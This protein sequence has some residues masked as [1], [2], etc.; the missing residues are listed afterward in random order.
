MDYIYFWFAKPLG[1]FVGALVLVAAMVLVAFICFIIKHFIIWPFKMRRSGYRYKTM[2]EVITAR[3]Y[4]PID[5]KLLEIAVVYGGNNTAYFS[6][7]SVDEFDRV[8][9][10]KVLRD[11][12]RHGWL[13]VCPKSG[14]STVKTN[15]LRIVQ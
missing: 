1:E 6:R 15:Y 14:G 12:A 11:G 8:L 7:R 4:K 3:A 10:S 5:A 9:F 13:S 2:K